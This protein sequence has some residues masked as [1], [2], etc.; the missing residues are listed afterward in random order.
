MR[1]YDYKKIKESRKRKTQVRADYVLGQWGFC[2]HPV[3]KNVKLFIKVGICLPQ[4][5]KQSCT[6]NFCR[7]KSR[8]HLKFMGLDAAGKLEQ[9]RLDWKSW[10]QERLT[11]RA[12]T[13]G[14]W[15][16]GHVWPALT[17][18]TLYDLTVLHILIIFRISAWSLSWLHLN[19]FLCECVS[20]GHILTQTKPNPMFQRSNSLNIKLLASRMFQTN[21]WPNGEAVWPQPQSDFSCFNCNMQ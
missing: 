1:A 18:R 20:G 6:T 10:Y 7:H 8:V 2:P 16:V 11:V 13:N 4:H 19:F 17:L 9:V 12:N 5:N 14:L 3:M 21:R 15:H